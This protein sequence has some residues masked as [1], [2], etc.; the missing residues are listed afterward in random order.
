MKC[1]KCDHDARA[2]Y[3]FC[4]RA[5]CRDH[6]QARKFTLG[7]VSPLAS[8]ANTVVEVEDAVW[9]GLCTVR[10]NEIILK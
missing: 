6:T 8:A 4:G 2:V 9:C 7:H 3:R 1:S 5:V 10:T